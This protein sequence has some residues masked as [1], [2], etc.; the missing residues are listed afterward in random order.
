LHVEAARHHLEGPADPALVEV[1]DRSGPHGHDQVEGVYDLQQALFQDCVRSRKVV[2]QTILGGDTTS[3]DLGWA[4]HAKV[5]R[6]GTHEVAY[7]RCRHAVEQEVEP[8]DHVRPP[9]EGDP[10][11]GPEPGGYGPERPDHPAWRMYDLDLVER[12]QW[13]RRHNQYASAAPGRRKW[14]EM[15]ASPALSVEGRGQQDGGAGI[16]CLSLVDGQS[17]GQPKRH[18]ISAYEGTERQTD[19][20]T[21]KALPS[22]RRHTMTIRRDGKAA[23]SL[24]GG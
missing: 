6:T 20:P 3:E 13:V 16:C 9:A 11:E 22:R 24:V 10:G 4:A 14:A 7:Q 18:E 17:G 21:D 5:E 12:T 19:Q 8:P 2:E 23:G 1:L 15:R